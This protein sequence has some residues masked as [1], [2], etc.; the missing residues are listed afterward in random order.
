MALSRRARNGAN[1]AIAVEIRP[2]LL[3]EAMAEA[4]VPSGGPGADPSASASAGGSSP[5]IEKHLQDGIEHLGIEIDGGLQQGGF[6]WGSSSSWASTSSSGSSTTIILALYSSFRFLMYAMA[7][8]GTFGTMG[9][10]ICLRQAS[11]MDG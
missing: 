1:F 11:R 2:G 4:T 3:L 8:F 9:R 6:S 10:L 7:G 5:P